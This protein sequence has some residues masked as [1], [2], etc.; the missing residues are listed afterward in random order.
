MRR[1]REPGHR[2]RA[3]LKERAGDLVGALDD[4]AEALKLD[5]KVNARANPLPPLPNGGPTRLSVADC[6]GARVTSDDDFA[7]LKPESA[8]AEGLRRA[9]ERFRLEGDRFVMSF[10]GRGAN[11][12]AWG[13]GKLG[14]GFAIQATARL[15]SAD[16]PGSWG[17]F[18]GPAVVKVRS[19]GT[20]EVTNMPGDAAP[21]P[22]LR[23]TRP[24]AR[25][26][27]TA[28]NALL[29][30]VRGRQLTVYLNGEQIGGALDLPSPAT[31]HGLVAFK[32]AESPAAVRAEFA[33]VTVLDLPD[34]K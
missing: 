13:G 19:D 7:R 30:V 14:R 24:V 34:R 8:Y 12:S 29:A 15:A 11:H 32:E 4:A 9:P 31:R 20:V 10:D 21:A 26:D 2:T 3:Y 18:F 5:P 28:P 16:A 22:A 25:V 33:R 6:A 17:L 23:P 27:P 1:G